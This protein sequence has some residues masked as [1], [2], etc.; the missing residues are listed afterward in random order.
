MKTGL[1]FSEHELVPWLLEWQDMPEFVLSDQAPRFQVIMNFSCE[2]DVLDFARL[3]GQHLT[4]S[5]GRQLQSLWFPEQ[6]I[7]RM[8]NKRYIDE[9]QQ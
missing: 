4:P 7:G 5:V 3:I 1:L 6:E 9:D 8:V 2:A